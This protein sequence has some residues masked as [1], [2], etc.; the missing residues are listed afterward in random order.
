MQDEKS[1]G[2]GAFASSSSSSGGGLKRGAFSNQ[3]L[4]NGSM[5]SALESRLSAQVSQAAALASID[6]HA[7]SLVLPHLPTSSSAPS[8]RPA[9]AASLGDAF[10]AGGS[11]GGS[12]D[13]N[14]LDWAEVQFKR[15]GVGVSGA[16]TAPASS[17]SA[18]AGGVAAPS[19]FYST[20]VHTLGLS[21]R[22]RHGQ[23]FG[24]VEKL[25]E[26][27]QHIFLEQ[28]NQFPNVES[29]TPEDYSKIWHAFREKDDEAQ[30]IIAK[31]N[32]LCDHIDTLNK[33]ANN[34]HS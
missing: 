15:A 16:P 23:L 21:Q 30:T 12:V 7:P 14:P 27:Q 22:A 6:A 13:L 24:V 11:N 25:R 26:G 28:F 29:H 9:T 34:P 3:S 32:G 17:S 19:G 1:S 10:N 33:H 20:P 31:L 5:P 18:A 4:G 2:S 8:I